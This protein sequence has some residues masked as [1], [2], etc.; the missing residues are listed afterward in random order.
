MLTWNLLMAEYCCRRCT[1]KDWIKKRANFH[2]RY[3]RWCSANGLLECNSRPA[4]LVPILRPVLPECSL[5]RTM[6]SYFLR[7]SPE[8]KKPPYEQDHNTLLGILPEQPDN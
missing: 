3:R 8:K 2:P 4:E 6:I 1:F 7:R 5:F